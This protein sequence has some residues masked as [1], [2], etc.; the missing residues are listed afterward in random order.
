MNLRNKLIEAWVVSGC[1]IVPMGG[2]CFHIILNSIEDQSVSLAFGPVIILQ[3]TFLATRWHL[4][5][6]PIMGLSLRNAI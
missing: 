5:F 2:G 1:K 3:G 6:D 4:G